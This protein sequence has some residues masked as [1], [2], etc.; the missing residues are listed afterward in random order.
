MTS[1]ECPTLSAECPCRGG[2]VLRPCG[3]IAF[4]ERS[5]RDCIDAVEESTG[6]DFRNGWMADSVETFGL[7]RP[8][9]LGEDHAVLIFVHQHRETR[10][11]VETESPGQSRRWVGLDLGVALTRDLLPLA[12]GFLDFEVHDRRLEHHAHD[13]LLGRG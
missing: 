10:D 6:R 11:R 3:A 2:R 7:W 13:G 4:T 5:E 9:H 1:S 8:G 12:G